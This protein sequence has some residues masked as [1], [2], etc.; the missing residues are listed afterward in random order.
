M[1]YIK[2]NIA[3]FEVCGIQKW[4]SLGYTGKGIKIANME[5]ANP[6]L[7][8]FD[9]K[10]KDP[11][12]HGTD[13]D[14]NLHGNK[15]M[16]VIH[17]VAPDSDIYM[18]SDGLNRTNDR[19]NGGN[20]VE[21]S[22]PF[23][24]SEGIHLVNA[25]LGGSNIRELNNII[26]ETQKHGTVFVTSAG[27]T[28]EKG[29]SGYARSGV[30]I[31]VGALGY[32]DSRDKIYLKDYSS[33][34]DELFVSCFSGLYIH[35][36]RNGYKGRTFIQEGTS[37]SSPMLCGMLALVQQFF[38]EKT[39]RTLYQDEIMEFIKDNVV[40][41]GEVGKDRDFGHGLFILPN[42]EDIDVNKYLL[43]D[44][45]VNPIPEIPKENYNMKIE[46]QIG[47]PKMIV[48]GKEHTLRVTPFLKNYNNKFAATCGELRP[49]FE[50][51]GYKVDWVE[52][53]NKIIITN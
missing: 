7:Y 17:Q 16:D 3:E 38:L 39:G 15:V 45:P 12:N 23:M 26:K 24:R 13:S 41:L 29:L 51:L 25:S 40:D 50:A 37:F 34:G 30:W 2:E 14:S 22:H 48:N 36:A 5:M 18:L 53:E 35:D 32:L 8:F 9:G 43:R 11:F 19:V 46:I 20:L 1:K 47:N 44:K 52:S 31:S 49:I 6:N 10:V 42:P 28:G 21:E 33:R 27:N 4:H